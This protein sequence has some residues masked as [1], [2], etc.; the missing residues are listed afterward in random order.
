MGKK[1]FF[2]W[3]IALILFGNAFLQYATG[4]PIFIELKKSD[5]TQE[6]KEKS[7]GDEIIDAVKDVI[8][9]GIEDI[10]EK[11]SK[12]TVSEDAS[13][14]NN[15]IP[16][17]LKYVVDGDTLIV[18]ENGNEYKIRLIGIDTAESV[19]ADEG[20]NTVW[21][22]YG[23]D[24]TKALLAGTDTLY[25]EYDKE[26]EDIY[27]RKL[28]YVWINNNT[29]DISNMLNYKILETGYAK[30]KV[31]MPN[32]KYASEFEKACLTAQNNNAGLWVEPEFVNL[33]K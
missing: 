12:D 1:T 24:N 32:D 8:G 25:L 18:T 30:D 27:G 22:T 33:W 5:I 19:H 16:V 23:S 11:N 20:K 3:I 7:L 13:E 14:N 29:S 21:G 2:L 15:L 4:N 9:S 26:K 28:A 17:A 6:T 31:Y 10:L